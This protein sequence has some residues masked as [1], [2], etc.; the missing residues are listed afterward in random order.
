MT[1]VVTGWRAAPL[2]TR[3]LE[4]LAAM[5]EPPSFEVIVS[6]NDPTPSLLSELASSVS[7][8][9]I[10]ISEANRGFG[11]ACN[12]AAKLARGRYLALLNDD[13]TAGPSWLGELVATADSD[14][15][16]GAVAG[17]LYGHDGSLVEAGSFLWSDGWPTPAGDGDGDLP[18]R[19]DWCRRVD[20]ASAA[21]LLIRR[22]VWDD[23]GGFDERYYPAYFEDADLCLRVA[24]HGQ[25][26]VVAPTSRAYH[27]RSAS[28]GD[29]YSAFLSSRNHEVF[30]RRWSGLLAER[31]QRAGEAVGDQEEALWVAMGKPHRVLVVVADPPDS[32]SGAV[33]GDLRDLLFRL[34]SQ[35]RCFLT[36]YA[37]RIDRVER[38]RLTRRGIRFIDSG[39][40]GFLANPKVSF[41]TVLTY[42][43]R[44]SERLT[45]VLREGRAQAYMC[46]QAGQLSDRLEALLRSLES[47]A[48]ALSGPPGPSGPP[49]LAGGSGPAVSARPLDSPDVAPDDLAPD[50]REHAEALPDPDPEETIRY[51]RAE[52][53]VREAYFDWMIQKYRSRISTIVAD[54]L[55]A[56]AQRVPAAWSLSKQYLRPLMRRV[57]ARG[58]PTPGDRSA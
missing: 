45:S 51:M 14:P 25:R 30:A 38:E 44:P 52:R 7:G 40:S 58:H 41:D 20:F 50:G 17:A 10:L 49:G 33:T 16:I 3:C 1:V 48:A 19:Y 24:T 11:G 6:L 32:S 43:G 37:P 5:D 34:A 4:S 36:L 13:A 57:L 23:L 35:S 53:E 9:T 55:A 15:G 12:A 42:G 21:S 31:P 56:H 46:S 18:Y 54:R 2:L 47:Q 28:S 27:V 29:T 8:A 39:L 26:V 22:S